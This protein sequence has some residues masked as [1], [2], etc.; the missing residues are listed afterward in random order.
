MR[1]CYE[2]RENKFGKFFIKN[3][4]YYYLDSFKVYGLN[5]KHWYDTI[6][7]IIYNVDFITINDKKYIKLRKNYKLNKRFN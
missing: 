2:L 7:Y 1:N 5:N 6:D 4:K 3:H